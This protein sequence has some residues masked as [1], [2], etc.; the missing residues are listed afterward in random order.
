[1]VFNATSSYDPDG[2]IVTYIWDFGDNNT[3]AGTVA[4]HAY[5]FEGIYTITLTVVDDDGST[6][7]ATSTILILR[8]DVAVLSATASVKLLGT[9]FFVA[10]NAT[11]ENQGYYT[12]TFNMTSYANTTAIQT[13]T[14]ILT[15]GYSANLTALW[16]TTAFAKGNY[17]I[18]VTLSEVPGETDTADNLLVDGWVFVTIPGDADEDRDVDIFDIVKIA[19]SYGSQLGEP[20][21]TTS[22]DIDSDGDVDIFDVVI[23]ARNYG[24]SW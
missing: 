24:E 11:V 18:S 19:I 7:N 23:A 2:A 3:A 16:N 4:E 8:R 9:Y 20:E 1:V 12:E 10:I 13:Q 5:A 17:T 6:G 22:C 21:Y 15:S 14:V